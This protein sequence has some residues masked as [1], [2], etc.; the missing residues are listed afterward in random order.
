[1]CGVLSVS[2]YITACLNVCY[3][4]M[5]N[6][7]TGEF[8]HFALIHCKN[9]S[10]FHWVIFKCHNYCF[11]PAQ[12]MEQLVYGTLKVK[13]LLEVFIVVQNKVYYN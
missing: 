8:I 7:A 5:E 6:S 2:C 3:I 13:E 12:K 1:M 10:P 4:N 11:F 9:I